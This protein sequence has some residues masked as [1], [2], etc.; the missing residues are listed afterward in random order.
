L[1]AREEGF[2]KGDVLRVLLRT[3]QQPTAGADFKSEYSIE[4]VFEHLSSPKQ[5]KFPEIG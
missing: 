3:S 2:F 5:E 4:K 1:D